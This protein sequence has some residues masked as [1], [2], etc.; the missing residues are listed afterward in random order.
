MST[1]DRN[2]AWQRKG[3]NII[4]FEIDSSDNYI[5]PSTDV[6]NGLM[7]EFVSADKVFVDSDGFSEDSNPT[8]NSYVNVNDALVYAVIEY[9]NAQLKR[10]AND[11]KGAKECEDRFLKKFR[12]AQD[13]LTTQPNIIMVPRV[14]SIR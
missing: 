11:I 8:E 4:F 2:W 3:K 6:A 7:I 13:G 5:P 1:I 12:K 14:Y 10:D 9:V